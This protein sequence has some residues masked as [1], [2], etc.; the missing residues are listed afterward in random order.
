MT[1]LELQNWAGNRVLVPAVATAPLAMAPT[2]APAPPPVVLSPK[3]DFRINGGIKASRLL[4]SN[5]S[6]IA[7]LQQYLAANV[8]TDHVA[9]LAVFAILRDAS[10]RPGFGEFSKMAIADRFARLPP[11]VVLDVARALLSKLQQEDTTILEIAQH[12]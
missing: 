1:A 5:Q 12:R 7:H 11:N 3:Q 4:A 8:G 2:P 6:A 10:R 9:Q